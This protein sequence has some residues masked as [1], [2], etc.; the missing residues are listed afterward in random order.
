MAFVANFTPDPVDWMH[1]GK[2]GVLEPGAIE[3]Y[4]QARVNHICHNRGARGI[5]QLQYGDDEKELTAKAIKI[6]EAFW[7]KQVEDHNE[8]NIKQDRE[9]QGYAVPTKTLVEHA[10]KLG[11][12]IWKPK[13]A[14][15]SGADGARTVDQ[16]KEAL[17]AQ[18]ASMEEKLNVLD[19]EK[20][21]LE[22]KFAVLE[23]KF[24]TLANLLMNKDDE[25]GSP[26]Q[27]KRPRKKGGDGE[28]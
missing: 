9:N 3:E 13:Y 24:D 21:E 27:E 17:K 1:G 22:A 14:G 25:D 4:E 10:E 28:P 18:V 23:G 26:K 15:T 20:K 19:P 12:E 7:R 16:E 2:D 11:L 6:F 5:L 8:V